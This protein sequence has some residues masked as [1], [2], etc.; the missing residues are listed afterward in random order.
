MLTFLPLFDL[1]FLPS[2]IPS[3]PLILHLLFSLPNLWPHGLRNYKQIGKQTGQAFS[4]FT[5][6]FRCHLFCCSGVGTTWNHTGT[7]MLLCI[8]RGRKNGRLDIFSV[9]MPLELGGTTQEPQRFC[10]NHLGSCNEHAKHHHNVGTTWDHTGTTRTARQQ[11]K[12]WRLPALRRRWD[13]TAPHRNHGAR[14]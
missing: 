9:E 14:V 2:C 6:N 7:T 13:H 1:S 5:Y 4:Q 11:R 3:A 10:A 8:S 12:E